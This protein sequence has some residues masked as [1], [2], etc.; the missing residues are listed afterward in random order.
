MLLIPVL[1]ELS[2]NGEDSDEI[3]CRGRR[4]VTE[5][6]SET[7]EIALSSTVLHSSKGNQSGRVRHGLLVDKRTRISSSH[8][9]E[10]SRV[11]CSVESYL[12]EM[13]CHVL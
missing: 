9:G 8:G 4:G 12:F 7:R 10:Q 1:S 11:F 13:P 5:A 6:S 2:D 3:K